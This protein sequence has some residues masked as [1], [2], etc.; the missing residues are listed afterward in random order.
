MTPYADFLYFGLLLYPVVPT[1]ILGLVGRLTRRWILLVT[2]A[3]LAVQYAGALPLW[4]RV[5]VGAIWVV[6]GYAL[7]QWAV[8]AGF[9]WLRARV[10]GRWPFYLAVGLALMP[11]AL[12]K[13]L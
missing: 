9:I 2:L 4:P 3:A 8:A 11:L 13:L 12:A 7:A 6:L 1:V 10:A 5:A